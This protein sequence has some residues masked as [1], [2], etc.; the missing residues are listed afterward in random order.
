MRTCAKAFVITILIMTSFTALAQTTGWI[1]VPEH[2][3]VKMRMMS[4]G[5]QSDNGGTVQTVLDVTLD[6]DWKTYWRSPG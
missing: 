1:S 4:T 6:G 3:P 2:P 5:E